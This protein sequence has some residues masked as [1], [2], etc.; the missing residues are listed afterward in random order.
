MDKNAEIT[1]RCGKV[2]TKAQLPWYHHLAMLERLKSRDD[3]FA[4][5]V[6]LVIVRAAA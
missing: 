5:V 1:R 3:R 6:A 4:Y 2:K